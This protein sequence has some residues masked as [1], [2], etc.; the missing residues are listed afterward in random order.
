MT[1][2][3]GSGCG[4][5][6]QQQQQP[7]LS[8]VSV[9]W[10]RSGWNSW[11]DTWADTEGLVERQRDLGTIGGIPSHWASSQKKVMLHLKRRFSMNS[12]RYFGRCCRQKNVEFPA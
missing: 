2:L 11:G 7:W 1:T 6:Q 9:Q 12:E 8:S 5:L 3:G 10:R 4:Q